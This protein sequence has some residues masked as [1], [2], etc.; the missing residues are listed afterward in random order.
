MSS[1]CGGVISKSMDRRLTKKYGVWA[2]AMCYVLPD[3]QYAKY[4]AFQKAGE[5]KEAK[6]IFDKY[7]RSII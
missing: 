2:T 1:I 6:K 5:E 3:K 4:I 7:G